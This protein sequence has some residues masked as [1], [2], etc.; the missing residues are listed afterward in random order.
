[1]LKC[2]GQESMGTTQKISRYA[3]SCAL[4]CHFM[5]LER[6]EGPHMIAWL[7]LKSFLVRGSV[8]S[9]FVQSLPCTMIYEEATCFEGLHASTNGSWSCAAGAKLCFIHIGTL[10]AS[11]HS[12]SLMFHK[13]FSACVKCVHVRSLLSDSSRA[14]L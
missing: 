13:Y 11:I 1:M 6:S 10:R 2:A 7:E 8:C 4:S 5:I 9:C 14:I 3:S 12:C